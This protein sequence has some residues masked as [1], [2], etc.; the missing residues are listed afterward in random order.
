MADIGCDD[1]TI[2]KV[3]ATKIGVKNLDMFD[4]FGKED[5]RLKLD[6]IKT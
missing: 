5:T 2:S 4:P 1:G 6:T 3:I